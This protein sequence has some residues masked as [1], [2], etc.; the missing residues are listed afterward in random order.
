MLETGASASDVGLVLAA[1]VFPLVASVL[2]G[3]VVAD[4]TSRRAVMVVA[5]LVRVASESLSRVSS[6]GWF[7]SLVF[8]PLGLAI[9][10]PLAAAIGISVALWLA[11]G[12]AVAAILALLTVPDIRRLPA[13]RHRR[14][15]R[16]EV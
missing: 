11:F 16:S 14:R 9:R 8:Y 1:G 13:I 15:G 5:D 4:R 6:Y 12:L 2:M 10:S 7:G 3:G